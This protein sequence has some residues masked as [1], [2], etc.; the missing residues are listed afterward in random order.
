VYNGLV[1]LYA[2]VSS[3][4]FRLHIIL[5]ISCAK[6][7]EFS[8]LLMLL[9]L[10]LICN[11][12]KTDF[13]KNQKSTANTNPGHVPAI[14]KKKNKLT[15]SQN[16]YKPQKSLQRFKLNHFLI[17]LCRATIIC[18]PSYFSEISATSIASREKFQAFQ[19]HGSQH[20]RSRLKR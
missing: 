12:F 16:H 4:S 18:H 7:I 19:F 9:R 13:T 20:Q 5:T 10:S 15:L 11:K 6:T 2:A 14:T 1:W 8:V 3:A 17:Q